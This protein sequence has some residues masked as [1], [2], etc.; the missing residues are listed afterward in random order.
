MNIKKLAASGVLIQIA[1]GMF[2]AIFNAKE[3]E[4]RIVASNQ[5]L[6]DDC[7]RKCAPKVGLIVETR[8]FPTSPQQTAE[9]ILFRAAA[10]ADNYFVVEAIIKLLASPAPAHAKTS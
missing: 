10:N 2:L 6:R 5:K 8:R 7:V 1:V 4:Q 3:S 9:T